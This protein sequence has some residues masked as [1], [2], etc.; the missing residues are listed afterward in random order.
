MLNINSNH[1]EQSLN[2]ASVLSLGLVNTNFKSTELVLESLDCLSQ[3]ISTNYASIISVVYRTQANESL[4][5][6]NVI[7]ATDCE[8]KASYDSHL[9]Q[10]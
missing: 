6:N 3:M 10:G 1:V 8:S 4:V 2:T 5:I 9:S 7:T